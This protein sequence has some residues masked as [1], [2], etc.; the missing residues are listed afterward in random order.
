[1]KRNFSIENSNFPSD[2]VIV[3]SA[4]QLSLMKSYLNI[5]VDFAKDLMLNT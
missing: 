1:M 3:T 5:I 2:L 4:F